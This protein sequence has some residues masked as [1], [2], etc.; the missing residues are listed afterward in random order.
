MSPRRIALVVASCISIGCAD[1]ATS[2]ADRL[3][4]AA[5]RLRS[6]DAGS[7]LIASY[8]PVTG[9]ASPY[10]VVFFPNRGVAQ[11]D[12]IAAGVGEHVAERI[13]TELAYLDSMANPLVVEQ[14]GKRLAFTTSW[15]RSAEVRD[16]VVSQR[17]NG[18]AAIELT[19]EDGAARVVAIR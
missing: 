9:G 3:G 7:S 15:T 18:P 16:L 6:G 2:L 13:Y 19:R 4:E 17:K 14:E 10:T 8:E 12:L 5:S 1:N 11:G